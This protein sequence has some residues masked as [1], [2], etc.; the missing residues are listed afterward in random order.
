[1][2]VYI[3]QFYDVSP[4]DNQIRRR[5]DYNIVWLKFIY[6]YIQ[7]LPKTT[8]AFQIIGILVESGQNENIKLNIKRLNSIWYSIV[9]LK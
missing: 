7:R 5:N 4:K 3:H 9:L 2:Y 8:N 6:L 1:M